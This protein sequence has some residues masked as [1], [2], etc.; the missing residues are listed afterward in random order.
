[1]NDNYLKY[2]E[3][4]CNK[5]WNNIKKNLGFLNAKVSLQC[6]KYI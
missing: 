5:K 1:M 4:K 3:I 6:K 2:F